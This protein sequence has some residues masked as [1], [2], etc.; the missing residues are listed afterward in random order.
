MLSRNGTPCS[1]KLVPWMGA[2]LDWLER[3]QGPQPIGQDKH[4]AFQQVC[5]YRR[6]TSKLWLRWL[7][8]KNSPEKVTLKS[9]QAQ[10]E[11]GPNR[12]S[13]GDVLVAD[14][15]NW[16]AALIL[17]PIRTAPDIWL[18]AIGLV[19]CVRVRN[20]HAAPMKPPMHWR[21]G[22]AAASRGRSW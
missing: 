17:E 18:I 3:V 20:S 9:R 5:F 21:F 13:F 22:R 8:C 10:T 14:K 16:S 6:G 12:V 11:T 4:A 2:S 7:P 19:S 15:N 1:A